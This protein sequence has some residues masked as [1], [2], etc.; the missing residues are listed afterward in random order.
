MHRTKSVA[1][2]ARRTN[3]TKHTR[4]T[5]RTK[6][7]AQRTKRMRGGMA[8]PTIFSTYAGIPAA[9]ERR[10]IV[11]SKLDPKDPYE[12]RTA[13]TLGEAANVALNATIPE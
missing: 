10:T 2:N 9:R 12:P 5:R 4:R 1:R 3:R 7:S 11:F 8:Q 6:R 13:M